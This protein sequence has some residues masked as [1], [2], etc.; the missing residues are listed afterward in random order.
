MPFE[1]TPDMVIEAVRRAD[2]IGN[3]MAKTLTK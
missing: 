1:V 2:G 3:Q